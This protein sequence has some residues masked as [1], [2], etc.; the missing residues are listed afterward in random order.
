LPTDNSHFGNLTT[1]A[2]SHLS[3]HNAL[4][5]NKFQQRK[6][7]HIPIIDF[8]TRFKKFRGRRRQLMLKPLL[9]GIRLKRKNPGL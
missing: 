3:L 4:R 1:V 6:F 2:I 5:N 8:M 9:L 7:F